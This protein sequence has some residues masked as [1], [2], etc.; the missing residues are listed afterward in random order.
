M[1]FL[2]LSRIAELYSTRRLVE[3]IG[4]ANIEGI[5]E[6]PDNSFEA[7]ARSCALVIP[8]LGNYRYEEA[9][10]RL[11][12]FAQ[13]AAGVRILN[14]PSVFHRARHKRLCLEALT[15]L[16]QP[17]M[18]A[19]ADVLPLVVKDC[20]SSKG[21]GVFLC[22]TSEELASCLDLLNGRE[23]LFQEFIAESAGR[24]VRAFVIGDQIVAAIERRSADSELEFR[25]NLALGG[26]ATM[27][28]LTSVERELC[29][30]SVRLLGLD[31]AGVD[32]VR[33]SRGPLL[34]EVN[35]CP[36][37]EGIEKCTGVNVAREVVQYA[38]SLFGADF[39]R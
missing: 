17:Q 32:F 19:A 8:R 24:D 5:V 14:E 20:L 27:T 12:A 4:R 29:L 31:Y 35:P 16:P 30:A 23:I 34:L 25:S 1:K 39:K 6:N 36:G 33:S 28:E 11:T 38:Q 15:D 13:A 18:R 21:E 22:R 26:S 37:F 7:S 9:M 2:I 3:E 10:A